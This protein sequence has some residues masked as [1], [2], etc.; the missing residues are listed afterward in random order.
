MSFSQ[1]HQTQG[2]KKQF[3]QAPTAVLLQQTMSVNTSTVVK[4]VITGDESFT[5][6]SANNA[7]YFKYNNI[8]NIEKSNIFN[9]SCTHFNYGSGSVLAN[10][11]NGEFIFNMSS[12][13]GTITSGNVSFK[14]TMRF[15]SLAKAVEW[16]KEQ[17]N[18]GTPVTITYETFE[19]EYVSYLQSYGK[20][21]IE[22]GY[23]VD[24]DDVL[25]M[26]YEITNTSAS[27][28]KFLFGSQ[29][30]S[31]TGL[32]CETYGSENKWYVRFGS[33]SSVNVTS[34]NSQFSGVLTLQR[35]SFTVNGSK[36]VSPVYSTMPTG[37]L[38]LFIRK[39][40][41]GKYVN[42]AYMKF[43]GFKITRNNAVIHEYKPIRRLSDGELGVMDI[44]TRQFLTNVGTGNFTTE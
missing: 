24:V 11:S 20:Q 32:W 26:E 12:A 30:Q 18:N 8:A 6:S 5:F 39:N 19:W 37:T 3:K 38:A 15:T 22:T 1:F 36:V 43:K 9:C 7:V 14:D 41:D 31:G 23:V 29:A 28:D 42:G 10:M 33:T 13:S 44:V 27:G 17:Y 4:L 2:G 16:F 25:E 21:A 34:T 40:Q 35:G